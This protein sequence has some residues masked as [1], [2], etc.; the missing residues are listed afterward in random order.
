VSKTVYVDTL[1]RY[2]KF[3]LNEPLK[4]Q[5]EDAGC[6]VK[7]IALEILKEVS[8]VD[9]ELPSSK[10]RGFVQ[11][12]LYELKKLKEEAIEGT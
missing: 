12:A 1:A 11:K 10:P 3:I 9:Y 4:K 8:P 5:Q 2:L 7:F 6:N